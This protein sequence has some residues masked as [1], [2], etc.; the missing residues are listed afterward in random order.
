MKQWTTKNNYILTRLLGGRSNVFLLRGGKVNVLIDTGTKPQ[1]KKLVRRLASLHIR[2]LDYLILTHTHNDHAANAYRIK[3]NYNASV[4]V[5]KAESH[6]LTEGKPVIPKG[7]N[8]YSRTLVN[9]FDKVATSLFRYDPCP[10]DIIIED[11]MDLKVF[12]YNGSIIHTPG[13]SSGSI[14]L[15]I[16][17]E[18]ALLGDVMIGRGIH[19]TYPPF[20]DDPLTL[21][22]S[23]KKLLDTNCSLFIPSHGWANKREL[24]EKV[25]M[26]KKK[27]FSLD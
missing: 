27:L 18:I 7:T 12:G 8:I 1:W 3:K 14:S 11:S 26:K 16:D 24:V 22:R 4:I 13:H 2:Q 20:A 17:D 21:I 25:Y 15:I 23:W 9:L 19:Y 5:H 6:H 10:A